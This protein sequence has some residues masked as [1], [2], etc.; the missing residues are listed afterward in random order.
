MAPPV[1]GPP[2]KP[3]NW[4]KISPPTGGSRGKAS[5]PIR[6]ALHQIVPADP[7]A[8]LGTLPITQ[9]EQLYWTNATPMDSGFAPVLDAIRA[10]RNSNLLPL[11]G[12]TGFYQKAAAGGRQASAVNT[13][14][15]AIAEANYGRMDRSL[16]YVSFIA[17]ELDV[18]QPGALRSY[19]PVPDYKYFP[20]FGGAM[21]M[22]AWSSYGI[23]SPLVESYLGIKPNAPARTLSVVPDLPSSL[24]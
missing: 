22:Q 6:L 17:D 2:G 11:P 4:S 10:L 24:E 7:P 15:M 16:R 9:F 5:L 20:S 8:A 14:V 3:A 1:T 21:V 12:N 23:H 18:E 19:S 13:G